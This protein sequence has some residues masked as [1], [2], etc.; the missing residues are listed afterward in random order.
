MNNRLEMI[1]KEG[2][3]S[4]ISL[5]F[6]WKERRKPRKLRSGLSA[7]GPRLEP[8]T[9]RKRSRSDNHPAAIFGGQIM[10]K[11]N[12]LEQLYYLM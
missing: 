7:S 4:G 5:A 11:E 10:K 3:I 1:W 2:L 6:A 9:S 12:I 8:G